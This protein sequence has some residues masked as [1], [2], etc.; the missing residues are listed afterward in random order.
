MSKDGNPPTRAVP[1]LQLGNQ[2]SP[3]SRLQTSQLPT[4]SQ[5]R[6]F[7]RDHFLSYRRMR[8]WR[9][10]HEEVWSMLEE[11]DGFERNSE[12][13]SYE[14]IHRA[15]LSGCLSHIAR[16]KEKNV[17]LGSKNR[18]I[19][20]FPGSGLFNRGGAW[21]MAAE[22]V[23]TSRL[24]ARTVATIEPEWIED[25]GKHLC[26]SVYFE[27]HWEKT[28]GQVV[29]YERVILYGLS[30]VERRKVNYSRVNLHEA[31]EIF[32]RSALV[33]GELPG[34]HAFLDHNREL[35]AQI[36]DLENKTRRRDL[37][38]DE[39][40]I[41]RFYDQRAPNIADAASLRKWFKEQGG[42][43]F[44]R[45]TEADLLETSPGLGDS[46]AIPQLPAGWRPRVAFALRLSSRSRRRWR[47]RDRSRTRAANPAC[48][49]I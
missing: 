36:E 19:M 4:R 16:K 14:A 48:S 35:I 40:T 22:Q 24:Y 9:D 5:M 11:L 47:D 41:F 39:E 38:V 45:M 27:P 21:T 37:L 46:R 29:A 8:E 12:P 42:D 25:L 32:I 23:Q 33:A 6:K 34:K 17:Y 43:H 10:I 15:L 20:L 7:C 44:L 31:R 18:Q 3:T 49:A 30:L 28:R 26:R 1:K 13:A 2:G